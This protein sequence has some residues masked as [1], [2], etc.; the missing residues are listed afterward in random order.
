MPKARLFACLL[1]ICTLSACG[2]DARPPTSPTPTLPSSN[3]SGVWRGTMDIPF[4]EPTTSRL[5]FT[6][7]T[8]LT[9]ELTQTG[10]NVAGTLRLQLEDGPEL[11]GTLTGTL[12]TSSSSTT[13]EYAASYVTPGDGNTNCKATFSGTMNVMTG[14]INGTVNGQNCVRP[15]SGNLHVTKSS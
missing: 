10:S 2:G 9:L 5:L 1:C 15:F 13:M 7:S 14:E 4:I 11:F 6:D 8:P 3:V 12:T